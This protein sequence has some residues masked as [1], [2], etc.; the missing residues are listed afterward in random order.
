MATDFTPEM[1]SVIALALTDDQHQ[2]SPTLRQAQ[3]KPSARCT[4]SSR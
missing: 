4:C 1:Q 2:R 3:G